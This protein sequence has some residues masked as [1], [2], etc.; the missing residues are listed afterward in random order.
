MKRKVLSTATHSFH[1]WDQNK[2]G[3]NTALKIGQN[4]S[5]GGSNI[6]PTVSVE[7]PEQHQ[8]L[9]YGPNVVRCRI[10]CSLLA[11]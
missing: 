7:K 4:K 3:E 6:E 10:S 8:G 11:A 9:L 5:Q 2:A 1:L